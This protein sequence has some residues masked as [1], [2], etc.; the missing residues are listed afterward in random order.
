MTD[1]K[2]ELLIRIK[3][4]KS[5]VWF[6][7]HEDLH[8]SYDIALKEINETTQYKVKRIRTVLRNNGH[9]YGI[10]FSKKKRF[11]FF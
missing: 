8:D 5:P 6:M 11:Y 7:V 4:E 10:H 2:E 9:W 3:Y 1:A